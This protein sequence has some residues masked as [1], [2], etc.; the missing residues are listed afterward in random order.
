[1]NNKKTIIITVVITAIII[2]GSIMLYKYE[3]NK[4]QEYYN[5]GYVTG[6]LYTSQSGNII[7]NN[8]GTI[9]EISVQEICRLIMQVPNG[10][11]E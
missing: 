11:Q 10:G 7:I 6:I 5:N 4:N 2:I 9:E 8:S 1:M 3:Q